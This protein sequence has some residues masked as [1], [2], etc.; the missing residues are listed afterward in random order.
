MTDSSEGLVAQMVK[1]FFLQSR[2]PISNLGGKIPWR[3]ERY[4]T[5]Y[6]LA[7]RISEG[8]SK[9]TVHGA[10]NSWHDWATNTF[11]FHLGSNLI[12]FP[13]YLA[14]HWLLV[15]AW[16]IPIHHFILKPS[17]WGIWRIFCS[18]SALFL[19][20]FW[21]TLLL[22]SKNTLTWPGRVLFGAP[23][24]WV[25]CTY[26]SGSSPNRWIGWYDF[27]ERGTIGDS[28]WL[29]QTHSCEIA[30]DCWCMSFMLYTASF[31]CRFL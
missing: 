10:T 20:D 16:N 3:R 9:T 31:S 7:W 15:K 6:Y 23:S 17:V 13:K 24:F 19:K 27:L 29:S 25:F 12:S 2:R 14:K 21:K 22:W 5:Q 26:N 18:L 8:A 28:F 4:H 1:E 11:T 30:F